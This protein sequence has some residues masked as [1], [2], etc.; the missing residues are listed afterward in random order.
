MIG[1]SKL[2]CG[3][4]EASDALR[5]GLIYRMMG[6]RLEPVRPERD[7]VTMWKEYETT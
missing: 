1:I 5:Y 3:Q 6:A 2:Y 7:D 4:V